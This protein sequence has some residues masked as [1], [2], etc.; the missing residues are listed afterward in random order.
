MLGEWVLPTSLTDSVT[1]VTEDAVKIAVK[2]DGKIENKSIPA[3]F[4]LWSTGIAMQP[5]TKRMVELLPNQY[6]SKACQVDAYLR[7]EGA[8][9]GTV[10]AIGDAATVHL[11]MIGDLLNLWDR[12]DTNKDDKM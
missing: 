10:Y 2:E 7:V 1:E 9:R 4:V 11:N 3:S 6:H 12:Y 5:F 8:P